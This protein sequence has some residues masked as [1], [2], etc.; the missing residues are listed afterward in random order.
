MRRT[1]RPGPHRL[2]HLGSLNEEVEGLVATDAA[3]RNVQ[4]S[5][6]PGPL[7]PMTCHRLVCSQRTQGR[8]VESVRWPAGHPSL[9]T[10]DLRP[11]SPIAIDAYGTNRLWP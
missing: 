6:T 5:A 10:R 8:R 7:R 3:S 11:V 2:G 1:L 4:N 9:P